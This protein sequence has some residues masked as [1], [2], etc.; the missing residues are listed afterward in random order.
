MITQF[1]LR[2]FKPKLLA[3]LTRLFYFGSNIKIGKNFKTDTIPKILIDK[4]C[5]L[6]IGD[7][8]EFR[9]NVEIRVHNSSKIIINNNVRIDRGVRLLSANDAIINLGKGCRI[10]LYSVLNGGDS[11][12]VGEK[13]LISGFVYLQTS[14]HNYNKSQKAVQD[15]GFTHSPI[16]LQDDTW[17]GTHVVILPGVTVGSKSIVGS[18]AVVS[19]SVEES[20]I[21]VGI[22]AKPI[23]QR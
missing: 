3:F 16:V 20:Q 15:Q 23:K 9:R 7:N 11:I 4:G 5:T 14:M 1:F 8:V 6:F 2:S 19:K 21:V 13:S 12:S 10:G 18:N 17:L 22:P